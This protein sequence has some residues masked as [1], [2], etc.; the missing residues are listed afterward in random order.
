RW[1]PAAP[2]RPARSRSVTPSAPAT[3]PPFA[4]FRRRTSTAARRA[5]AVNA[6]CRVR[7]YRPAAAS[8]R[9]PLGGTRRPAP[10][11]KGA[12]LRA[13][14]IIPPGRYTPRRTRTRGPSRFGAVIAEQLLTAVTPVVSR[15][16]VGRPACKRRGE[17]LTLIPGDFAPLDSPSP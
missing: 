12:H 2:S 11:G 1:R 7:Q 16:P 17:A 4:A 6:S 14:L 10:T 8:R 9:W 3:G 13:I 5:R 15:R